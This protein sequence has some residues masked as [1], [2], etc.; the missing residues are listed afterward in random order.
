MLDLLPKSYPVDHLRS[1]NAALARKFFRESLLPA[2][3]SGPWQHGRIT[4]ANAEFFGSTHYSEPMTNYATGWTDPEGW[5]ALVEYIAPAIPVPGELFQH[6]QF[7][8]AE[9]FLA[10]TANEDLRAINAD[11]GT[12][13]Y[14]QNMVSRR[15]NNRGLRIE[16]DY[17]RIKN[18]PN[19]QAV[20]TAKLLSRLKR[21]QAKRA[22]ALAIASGSASTLH[23]TSTPTTL[24]DIMLNNEKLLSRDSSG[25]TPN[26]L[27][28]GDTAWQYRIACL[29]SISSGA[30]QFAAAA[31]LQRTVEQLAAW[32]GMEV[33]VDGARTQSGT[34]KARLLDTNIL[35]FN[36]RP[37]AD[38]DD[39]SSFK[40]AWTSCA[41]GMRWA[42]YVRQVTTKKWE[43]VVEHYELLFAAS[44][45]GVLALTASQS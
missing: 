42:V 30:N 16:L 40:L 2:Q 36:A 11:F 6:V 43:I 44:T 35:Y 9:E 28:M 41:N 24:P 27:L 25:I 3:N 23:W 7:T 18:I 4:T 15:L 29:G 19:W 33:M 26:R 10:D 13:D 8:N 34:T 12:V 31:E 14:T 22:V 32:L 38:I 20:Y 39:P 5:D 21:N 45:L 17:D 1:A 37:G